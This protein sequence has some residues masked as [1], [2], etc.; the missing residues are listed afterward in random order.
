MKLRMRNTH[1]TLT[2]TCT[3][4]HK[5]RMRHGNAPQV[6]RQGRPGRLHQHNQKDRIVQHQNGLMLPKAAGAAH[7]GLGQQE[8]RASR[9]GSSAARCL[10]LYMV[11]Q[12]AQAAERVA[13]GVQYVERPANIKH[14]ICET[15]VWRNHTGCHLNRGSRSRAHDL[16]T[17]R[18]SRSRAYGHHARGGKCQTPD[19]WCTLDDSKP[20]EGPKHASR[21]PGTS[22][23]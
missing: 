13:S 22:S 7:W 11:A 20:W 1:R 12:G 5:L 10:V 23:G 9:Q 14:W 17:D 18:G 3:A 16:N 2:E 6:L 8:P 19:Q 4:K 15:S 21:T